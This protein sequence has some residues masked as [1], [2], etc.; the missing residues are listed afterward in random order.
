MRKGCRFGKEVLSVHVEN[1]FQ[2]LRITVK[3]ISGPA[4][5][6]FQESL[7]EMSNIKALNTKPQ[8][9]CQQEEQLFCNMKIRMGTGKFLDVGN[10]G[11]K[12]M[13]FHFAVKERH[14]LLGVSA[15]S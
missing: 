6:A 15:C 1:E 2:E 14:S 4:A 7:L 3:L 9:V 10:E 5:V 13:L 8:Y 12:M 11:L